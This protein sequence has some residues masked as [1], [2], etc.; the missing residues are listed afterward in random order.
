MFGGGQ[1]VLRDTL[2]DGKRMWI[3]GRI[4]SMLD[5]TLIL[6]KFPESRVV[7]QGDFKRIVLIVHLGDTKNNHLINEVCAVCGS[8]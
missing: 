8:T 7:L 6:D 3:D 4:S 2:I 5:G 1:L